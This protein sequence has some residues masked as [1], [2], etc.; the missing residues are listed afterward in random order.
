MGL[1]IPELGLE[2]LDEFLSTAQPR[3]F[4]SFLQC[5]ICFT[6]LWV[7]V[8]FSSFSTWPGP[9][10]LPLTLPFCGLE[11][12]ISF[13]HFQDLCLFMVW[14]TTEPCSW[15]PVITQ[16]PW[17]RGCYPPLEKE[18]EGCPPT[19]QLLPGG[20]REIRRMCAAD[21][22]RE[23]EIQTRTSLPLAWLPTTSIGNTGWDG[24]GNLPL[25]V[26]AAPI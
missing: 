21:L 17:E 22:E 23:L 13:L 3:F 9:Q 18:A 4:L 26:G 20:P 10:G 19:H 1:G 6:Q 12:C 14:Q 7:S 25:S 15:V 11:E 8:H 5:T 2:K 16:A 24:T